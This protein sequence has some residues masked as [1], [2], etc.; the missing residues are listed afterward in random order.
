MHDP[1]ELLREWHRLATE[2]GPASH[3]GA[4]CVSTVDAEG[5]PHARVVDLKAIRSDG[6][7]FCT[8]YASPKGRQID[9]NPNVSLSFWWDHVGRQVRVLGSAARIT[10][11]EADRF[12]QDRTRDAQ[13]ASWAFDQSAP[14]ADGASSADRL[15]SIQERFRSGAVPRP[16][17]WGGYVVAPVRVEFLIFDRARA[18]RRTLYERNGSDWTVLE[19]QP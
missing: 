10:A 4:V 3:P 2:A 12:F 11:G 5:K 14:F 17:Q 16:R 19:L 8:S 15:A 7:V 6:L 13:L 9:A 1:I 18:H